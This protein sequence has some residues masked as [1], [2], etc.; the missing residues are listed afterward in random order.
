MKKL[1]YI[2][3]IVNIILLNYSCT[4]VNK[5]NSI[6]SGAYKRAIILNDDTKMKTVLK[7]AQVWDLG[8]SIRIGYMD[9]KDSSGE[10]LM[11][12][13]DYN[14]RL[15]LYK[16]SFDIDILSLP[17]KIRPGIAGIPTQMNSNFNAAFYVGKKFDKIV[18]S[19]AMNYAHSKDRVILSGGFG[20]GAFAGLG[21][22]TINEH[23]AKNMVDIEYEGLAL[24][25][26]VAGIYDAEAFNIGLAIGIDHLF[27]KN[28][29]HWIYQNR[30]WIGVLFGLN[31][32]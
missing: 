12:T 4:A 26:G 32:N 28:R 25:T 24:V 8:D 22:V 6:D 15:I 7:N 14:S 5:I 16:T 20:G 23:V 31:L 19:S 1:L 30:P 10:V 11:Y 2:F 29:H 13:P 27:D 9:F 18:V 3:I 17:F 21:S